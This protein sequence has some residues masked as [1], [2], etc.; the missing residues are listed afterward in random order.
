MIPVGVLLRNL[1]AY[2][3]V[4]MLFCKL[5]GVILRMLNDGNSNAVSLVL[6]NDLLLKS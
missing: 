5:V 4:Y 1:K 2:D 6:L 3:Y